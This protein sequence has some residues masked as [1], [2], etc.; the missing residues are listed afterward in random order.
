MPKAQLALIK[1]PDRTIDG[2]GAQSIVDNFHTLFYPRQQCWW[3]GVE[4]QKCPLDLF[5]YQEIIY[6][7]RPDLIIECGTWRGGSALYLSHLFDILQHGMVL[8]IDINRWVGFPLHPRI[9]YLTGS[10]LDKAIFKQ[11]SEFAAGFRK[12]M[13]ILDS[14]HAKQHVL[15]ELELYSE[16]VT[17]RQYLIVEDS[18]IHGHPVLDDL[19]PG[20]AEAL[21]AWVTKQDDF[22]QDR[23]CERFLMTFNPGGYLRKK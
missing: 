2:T 13:V 4:M 1:Q 15:R 12:V 8:T 22:R 5:M 20:P 16:L 11:A 23:D 19:P 6:E 10:S 21:E 9:V 17:S 18:N 14:D 3:M 7:C